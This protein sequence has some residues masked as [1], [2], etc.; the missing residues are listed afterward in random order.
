MNGA[1]ASILPK[2]LHTSKPSPFPSFDF[3]VKQAI[4]STNPVNIGQNDW[5]TLLNVGCF[6]SRDPRE[7]MGLARLLTTKEAAADKGKIAENGTQIHRM[8]SLFAWYHPCVESSPQF[9]RRHPQHSS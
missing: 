6:D 4:S 2:H 8:A 9:W 3:L 7:A 1:E 5:E